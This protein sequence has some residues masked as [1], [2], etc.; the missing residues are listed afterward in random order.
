MFLKLF[1]K[2]PQN[3]HPQKLSF[4]ELKDSFSN[5]VK[6]SNVRDQPFST[7]EFHKGSK[8]TKELF[9]VDPGFSPFNG[10]THFSIKNDFSK[11]YVN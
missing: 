10:G 5:A 6:N 4:N 9:V 7:T 3:K 11:R 1:F 8:P 2:V